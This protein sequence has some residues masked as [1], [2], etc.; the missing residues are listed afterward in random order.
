M[1]VP[2]RIGPSGSSVPRVVGANDEC[3]MEMRDGGDVPRITGQGTCTETG[4]VVEKMSDDLFDDVLRKP[5][6]RRR[7]GRGRPRRSAP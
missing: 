3:M 7:A 6:D 1:L 2:D 5:G 4:L